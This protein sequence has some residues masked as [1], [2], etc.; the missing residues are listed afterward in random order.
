MFK[1]PQTNQVGTFDK[2]AQDMRSM[3]KNSKKEPSKGGQRLTL[4]HFATIKQSVKHIE[5]R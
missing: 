3:S 1:L 4:N 2:K 5:P